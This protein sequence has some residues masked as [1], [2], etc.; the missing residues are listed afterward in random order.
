MKNYFVVL[1]EAWENG[2][3]YTSLS[4]YYFKTEKDARNY[5]QSFVA[6]STTFSEFEIREVMPHI[7]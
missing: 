4:N 1:F 6:R 2:N 5:A 3:V 7:V